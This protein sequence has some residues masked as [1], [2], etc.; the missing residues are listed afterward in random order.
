M[1]LALALVDEVRGAALS[2]MLCCTMC[3]LIVFHELKLQG[4]QPDDVSYTSMIWV[5]CK[6]GR[7]GEA[8]ELFGQMEVERAVPCAYAYNTLI[9]GYGSAGRFDDAYRLL[10]RL[11][12]RGCIPSIVSFNSI[13]TCLGKKRKVDDAL[14]LLDIMKKDAK[15]NT[16]TYNIVIDVLCMAGRVIEAYKVQDEMELAGMLP[17]LLTFNIMV[18]RLCKAKHLEEGL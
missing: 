10:E 5:L 13:L 12:E 14:S 8:E 6:A 11:R 15:P 3:A 7:L 2:R 4:L 9:M 1:E 17:N 16:S 18:D